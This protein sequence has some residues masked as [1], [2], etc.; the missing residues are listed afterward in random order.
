LIF[1]AAFAERCASSRTSW[2]T[3]AKLRPRLACPRCLDASVQRQQVRLERNLINDADDL[4]DLARGML[5]RLMA[6]T[7]LVTMV[8][9][10]SAPS[11][12][13]STILPTCSATR[14]LAHGLGQD[15][16]G[17]RSFFHG[18]RLTLGAD[19]KV[20][21]G[22]TDFRGTPTD[23]VDHVTSLSEDLGFA[24]SRDAPSGRQELADQAASCVAAEDQPKPA[25]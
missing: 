10:R 16:K 8:P 23:R 3:T 12:A 24:R 15:A 1:L 4:A 6:C 5:N 20:M 14:G 9:E 7:A 17:A 22:L 19:R 13:F 11:R 18:N 21:R 2:A 25:A